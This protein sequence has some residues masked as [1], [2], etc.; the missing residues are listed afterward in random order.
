LYIADP[1]RPCRG[2]RAVESVVQAVLPSDH[3]IEREI[4]VA[5]RCR[6]GL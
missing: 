4:P 3:G 6:P 5:V 1:H 2:A